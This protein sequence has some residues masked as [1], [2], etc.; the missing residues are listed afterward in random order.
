MKYPSSPR[1]VTIA[2]R[3]QKSSLCNTTRAANRF[4]TIRSLALQ[5]DRKVSPLTKND[6]R[7][8]KA[9][10]TIP[11]P[12]TMRSRN[13]KSSALESNNERR[14]F[15]CRFAVDTLPDETAAL[16]P[17]RLSMQSTKHGRWSKTPSFRTASTLLFIALHSATSHIKFARSTAA[18]G[19]PAALKVIDLP[20]YDQ[21]CRGGR[22]R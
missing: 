14:R 11:A 8:G 3:Y 9:K 13:P 17:H 15:H 4:V 1:H 19:C 5:Q 20:L 7:V 2:S 21:V 6:D 22:T 10:P 18:G 16:T 12:Q